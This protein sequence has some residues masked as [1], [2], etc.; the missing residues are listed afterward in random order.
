MI[1]KKALLLLNFES[2]L[3][4]VSKKRHLKCYLI[5]NFKF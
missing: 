4:F 5:V 1:N 3:H 2:N